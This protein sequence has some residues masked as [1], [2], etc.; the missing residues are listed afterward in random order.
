[1][2]RYRLCPGCG[3]G[4]RRGRP[5]RRGPGRQARRSPHPGGGE[6]YIPEIEAGYAQLK[7]DQRDL[8]ERYRDAAARVRTEQVKKWAVALA[9]SL[10]K[11]LA[12]DAMTRSLTWMPKPATLEDARKVLCQV[13]RTADA[14]AEDEGVKLL[15]ECLADKSVAVREAAISALDREAWKGPAVELLLAALKDPSEKVSAAAGFVLMGRGDQRGLAVVL[16]GALSKDAAVRD[17]CAQVI[18][19]LILSEEGK[20]QR[21]RFKHTPEE[22]AALGKLLTHEDFNTRGTVMRVLG[23]SGDKSAGPAL[24][25]ALGKETAAKNLRRTCASLGWL[26]HRPA[27]AEMLK[28]IEKGLRG[29]KQD[30]GWGLAASW[31]DIGDPDSVPAMIALLGNE[32]RGPYAAAALSWAFGMEGADQDYTRGG[33]P[34]EVFVPTADGKFE[35]KSGAAVPKPDELKKLWEAFWEKNKDKYKWSDEASTL[36]PAPAK[37]EDKK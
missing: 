36:R 24:L 15:K 20:P 12:W 35:K 21:A 33:G 9:P 11:K 7:D 29:D 37:T 30:Y 3:P 18:P 25:D 13:S 27:A 34:G 32:K 22:I 28:L 31:A 8:R 5:G 2:R 17:Q 4:R 19:Q 10:E 26:R 23:M 14:W 1:L 16:T 6:K